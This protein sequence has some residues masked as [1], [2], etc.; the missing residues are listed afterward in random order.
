[1]GG[2]SC[3]GK[4]SFASEVE[5]NNCN[6]INRNKINCNRIKISKINVYHTFVSLFITWSIIYHRATH[7]LSILDGLQ[8]PVRPFGLLLELVPWGA[9]F[10]R[11]QRTGDGAESEIGCEI[12]GRSGT[13]HRFSCAIRF[14][15]FRLRHQLSI[16]CNRQRRS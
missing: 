13:T 16:S 12:V 9:N 15:N 8:F 6:K 4:S 2:E 1:M 10:T 5:A 11:R 14:L 7:H 3:C